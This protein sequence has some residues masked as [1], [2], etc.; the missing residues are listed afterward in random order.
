MREILVFWTAFNTWRSK[1]LCRDVKSPLHPVCTKE[2]NKKRLDFWKDHTLASILNQNVDRW[3][4]IV[5]LDPSLREMCEPMLP[6]IDDRRVIYSYEGSHEREMLIENL[7]SWYDSIVTVRIDS[8]DMYARGAGREILN[9]P[10]A[11][12]M[13]FKI[14]FGYNHKSKTLYNYDTRTS[15]PFF[16]HRYVGCQRLEQ[17]KEIQHQRVIKKRPA[18]LPSGQFLVNITGGNTTTTGISKHFCGVIWKK[19]I[20]RQILKKFGGTCG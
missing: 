1:D 8:D 14:G 16:A 3:V 18:V 9:C 20:E 13:F 7:N 5:R 15:G 11:E 12:W 17:I 6:R 2:W 10:D 19:S 4:Y